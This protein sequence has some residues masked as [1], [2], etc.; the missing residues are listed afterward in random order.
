VKIA[1]SY[2]VIA[3]LERSIIPLIGLD[4][5]TSAAVLAAA[6]SYIPLPIDAPELAPR[7]V[8]PDM[9]MSTSQAHQL[10]GSFGAGVDVVS[11]AARL[12]KD[13]GDLYD[14]VRTLIAPPHGHVLGLVYLVGVCGGLAVEEAGTRREHPMMQRLGKSVYDS[15]SFTGGLLGHEAMGVE[16]LLAAAGVVS[17]LL[18]LAAPKRASAVDEAVD[19]ADRFLARQDRV[20]EAIRLTGLC[21]E[22]IL[23]SGAPDRSADLSSSSPN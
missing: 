7:F 13:L 23:P 2:P 1:T 11:A 20:A 10:I 19:L 17:D 8:R 15:V 16:S 14:V 4:S 18:V 21:L 3:P 22:P 6:A 9:A 5:A 12:Q